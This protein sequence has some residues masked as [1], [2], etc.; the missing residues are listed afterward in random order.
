MS[1][2]ECSLHPPSRL[3]APPEPQALSDLSCPLRPPPP[4]ASCRLSVSASPSPPWPCRHDSP[5]VCK[6]N[7]LSKFFFFARKCMWFPS[8]HVPCCLHSSWNRYP[9]TSPPFCL[10]PHLPCILRDQVSTWSS[11]KNCCISGQKGQGW[12]GDGVYLAVHSHKTRG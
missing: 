8:P 10:H 11:K 4:P 5:A 12:F 3:M 7:K 1:G 9:T 6:Y 2:R